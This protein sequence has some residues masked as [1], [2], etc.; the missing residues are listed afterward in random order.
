MPQSKAMRLLWALLVL[1]H[2]S[3]AYPRN[4][5]VLT[6]NQKQLY[7]IESSLDVSADPCVNFYNYACG[8]WSQQH[9]TGRY[10]E[11]TGY[12]D[13]K[14]NKRFVDLLESYVPTTGDN[15]HDVYNKVW[16]YYKS[17]RREKH[18]NLVKYLHIVRPAGHLNW[19]ELKSSQNNQINWSSENFNWMLTLAKLHRFGLKGSL[20]DH[21]ILQKYDNARE[22][23][24][25]LDKPILDG[26]NKLP[27]KAAIATLLITVGV[28]KSKA[29]LIANELL[30]F[31]E[32]L[33]E[34]LEIDDE[35]GLLNL[36]VQDLVDN[37]PK[38][39]WRKYFKI[40]F[41][42]EIDNNFS[43]HLRNFKYFEEL[44]KFMAEME[45][46]LICNYLMVKFLYYLSVDTTTSFD[47]IDCM[48]DV[49]SKM[50]YAVNF[51]Y[52]ER[53]YDNKMDL[54]NG[55]VHNIMNM[56]RTEFLTKIKQ[57]ILQFTSAEQELLTEKLLKMKI[58]IGNLPANINK[59]RIEAYYSDL[60]L[61][62]K[63][64]YKNHLNLLELRFIKEH[65]QLEH[66]ITDSTD[67]FFIT[68]SDTARSSSP[69]YL[70][71]SNMII[72]PFGVLQPPIFHKSM[73]DVF[74]LSL[75]GFLMA[76]EITHGFDVTGVS[77]DYKGDNNEIGDGITENK[78]YASAVECM[79]SHETESIDERIAD[80]VGVRLA[81]DV[82]FGENSTHHLN[83]KQPNFTKIPVKKLF[84]LNFAQFFC[85]NLQAEFSEHDSDNV[86]LQETLLNFEPFA[87]EFRCDLGDIMHPS[88][89]CRLW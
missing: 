14:V 31:E 80:I 38:I 55:E 78:N 2:K 5:S 87:K 58:N 18:I 20:I 75:L 19:P 79:Q 28:E 51:I 83:I 37:I 50:D 6:V 22:Y 30:K 40:I 62:V 74:K 57:N 84:F 46:K 25:D 63:N 48:V 17:C 86:R 61:D 68:D 49:R 15:S 29:K 69:F 71:Q 53:F 21:I 56:V 44:S 16:M 67:F 89:K 45:P 82:L 65:E 70:L 64:Y 47:K 52:K 85:G 81:Y 23:V 32:K 60:Q 1:L 26:Q 73:H 42:Y 54:Y 35:Y 43:V 9:T 13:H 8:N 7:V 12:I 11:N 39:P 88:V 72:V 76:H 33:A 4:S 66:N 77:Y 27:S 59:T 3:S 24:I 41:E 10:T 34:L 36:S